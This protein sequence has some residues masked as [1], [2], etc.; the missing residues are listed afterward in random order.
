MPMETASFVSR[1]FL[2]VFLWVASL[3]VVPA[4]TPV[5]SP[6]VAVVSAAD[7]PPFDLVRGARLFA[8]TRGTHLSPGDLIKTRPGNI[9][10]LEFKTGPKVTSLAAIGPSSRIYWMDQRDSV[11]LAVLS[12]WIKIDTLTPGQQAMVIAEGARLHAASDAGSYVMHVSDTADEVFHERGS[13]TLELSHSRGAVNFRSVDTSVP[14]RPDQLTRRTAT[15][16]IQTRLSADATF[17]NALPPTFL[18]P[19]PAGLGAQLY[20]VA[21]PQLVRD[22]AYDDVADWLAAPREWR[23]GFVHR[24][25]PR[26]KD[27]AFF[28]ALDAQMTTHPEWEPILHPPEETLK[29]SSVAPQH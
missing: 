21:Q 15:G 14:S 16:Q 12:G 8:G 5:L 25:R 20:T 24:F 11:K 6:S 13:M 4:A 7:G 10:I 17:V 23:R 28:D 1:V 18:D 27:P 3:M 29:L 22:V 2:A 9:L 19:I 26:L